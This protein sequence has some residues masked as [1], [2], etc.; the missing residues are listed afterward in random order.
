MDED[1]DVLVVGSGFGGSVTALRLSEKGYRVGVLEAGRRFA[2]ADLPATSWDVRRFLWAPRL[3]CTGIQRIHVLPDVVVLAGAGVGGG[4]LVYAGTL[5]RPQ[6]D[7]FY[8]D[9]QWAHL[10]DWREELAPFYDQAER[11]L[12]VVPSRTTTPCDEVLRA[13]ADGMGAGC[14]V[15]SVPVGVFFGREGREEPGVRVEDPYFGGAGP[16]RTGCLQCGECMS[17]CRHGAK[18]TLVKNY[19]HLAER[20]G[21]RVHPLTA[22]VAL[23]PRPGGGYAVDA[24]PPGARR[25]GRA[26]RTFT[27]RHVVLAAGTWGTQ[28]LLHRM[29]AEGHLPR[30]SPRLGALTRTNSESIGGVS[31]RWRDRRGRDF[32]RGTAITSALDLDEHTRVEFV[33]YGHGSNAMGLL[34]TVLTDGGGRLPRWVAWLVQV[35]RHPG[36]LV[37]HLAGLRHWS[38]R[39]IISLVMQS[40]DNSITVR[41]T[42]T[43]LGRF[44]LTSGPGHG[45][46]NPTWIPAA[47]DVLRRTAALVGGYPSGNAGEVLDAPMTAHFL[48][49]CA[50]GGSPEHGVVDAYHRVFGHP[51]LHVVDGSAVC[52]NLG[53]NPSLT[54]AAQAERAAAFWPN[55]GEADP[56]PPLGA[57]YRRLP[58][59]APHRPAVPAHAPTALRLRPA[60]PH[61]GAGTRPPSAG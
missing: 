2:D 39:T 24:V 11:M 48:G 3:G 27:A 16:P 31:V 8:R 23:R 49:G 40:H 61:A 9:P 33:R 50:I 42:R 26:A 43:R 30:L 53:V 21:A 29:R 1:Y 41:G 13:V 32:T 22:A 18:N 17:G 4:S 34:Q 19:L 36:L 58:P 10:A 45:P 54:I 55:R 14:R 44:A 38:E 6:S 25:C 59:V 35:L 46:P 56:R 37:S 28:F 12:G 20:A 60:G 5:Y 47:A 51:G 57:P 52:A 15:T 7:T